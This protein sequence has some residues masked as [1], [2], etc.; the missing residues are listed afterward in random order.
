M[1]LP[2]PH[3]KSLLNEPANLFKFSTAGDAS[4]EGLKALTSPRNYCKPIPPVL[5]L[6]C[7]IYVCVSLTIF[8]HNL[9]QKGF[10]KPE[11]LWV[12]TFITPKPNRIVPE[13]LIT[14]NCLAT[15]ASNPS[16]S[17]K[18]FISFHLEIHLGMWVS[19]FILLQPLW[20]EQLL[21]WRLQEIKHT[22]NKR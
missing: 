14:S 16:F 4:R 5:H 18:T 2:P 6:N 3:R 17:G 15:L 22:D 9:S 21:L 8:M 20:Y 11:A 19:L 1:T 7:Y 12:S 10:P 13:V